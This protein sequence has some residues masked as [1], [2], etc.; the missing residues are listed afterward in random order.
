MGRLS[1]SVGRA[2]IRL[3]ALAA[4][5]AV[6]SSA[7]AMAQVP[8]RTEK[9]E[10]ALA[11]K[12]DNFAE[13]VRVASRRKCIDYATMDALQREA[14]QINYDLIY[15]ARSDQKTIDFTKYHGGNQKRLE[16]LKLCPQ[17]EPRVGMGPGPAIIPVGGS[18][19]SLTFAVGP[20]FTHYTSS[21]RSTGSQPSL[22]ATSNH[23]NTS[24]CG[25]LNGY[26]PMTGVMPMGYNGTY[27]GGINICGVAG[28]KSELF[29]HVVHPDNGAVT[30]SVDPGPRVEFF[31]GAH[32]DAFGPER[33]N[34]FIFMRTGPVFASNRLSITSDQT[35]AKGGQFESASR[36]SVT[37]GLML[38]LGLSSPL[39]G[40]CAF[41]KPLRWSV[42]GKGYWFGSG[43][44]VS[45]D[46]A[47]FGFKETAR[48][49]SSH[50]YST[51][52]G[53]GM[54]F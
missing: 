37:T 44:S 9:E 50:E 16:R 23:T 30:A 47:A 49:G 31:I 6:L 17:T 51:N 20:S 32:W 41:G 36:S 42:S 24:I 7:A 13:K 38:E 2:W 1:V 45:V 12:I 5:A 25:G 11:E 48:I 22:D 34:P 54:A 52:I 33:S 28:G 8:P 39:C 14:V 3:L 19:Y 26:W 4:A 27:G 40:D 53:L 18:P 15:P 10:Q 46:S 21:Y 35:G 29:R 43:G